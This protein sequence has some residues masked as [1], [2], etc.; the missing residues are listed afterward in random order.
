MK[1][2]AVVYSEES[3][4]QIITTH[5]GTSIRIVD[6][7]KEHAI[8]KNSIRDI[9]ESIG[10]RYRDVLKR[11][12]GRGCN[13]NITFVSA[14]LSSSSYEVRPFF[15]NAYSKKNLFDTMKLQSKKYNFSETNYEKMLAERFKGIDHKTKEQMRKICGG[16]DILKDYCEGKEMYYSYQTKIGGK[17]VNFK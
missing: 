8:T 3:N 13:I 12:K 16:S 1:E 9:C 6:V 10:T 4:D 7:Y 15:L 11:E 2:K 5:S 17:T 14:D